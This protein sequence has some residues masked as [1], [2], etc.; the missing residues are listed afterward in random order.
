MKSTFLSLLLLSCIAFTSCGDRT[1]KTTVT[2]DSTQVAPPASETPDFR[3]YPQYLSCK[4]EG[5][6]YVAYYAE[7]HITGITN[8]LNMPARMVFATS[9]D[10]E[11]LNGQTK[12][13]ELNLTFFGL[14]QKGPGTYTS[15]KDF[16]LDGHTSFA[17]GTG[18]KE[19]HFKTGEGQQ[20]TV[21]SFKEGL[22][23]GTFSFDVVDEN[24]PA[25]ILKLTDGVFKLQQEGET[26]IQVNENGDVNM[27]S[28]MK[29]ING[30]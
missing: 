27:D 7:G 18:L 3:S 21:T 20:L 1:E 12:I 17:E 15:T 30:D 22:V 25:H 23:E 6:V 28:L 16:Y 24:N 8:A 29:S 14:T 5:Q 4:I 13:S 19:Y 26:K 10:Q 9:A 2:S 11:Q